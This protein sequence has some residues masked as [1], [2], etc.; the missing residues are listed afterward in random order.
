MRRVDLFQV[1]LVL[2]N[3]CLEDE[4]VPV[5]QVLDDIKKKVFPRPL[6]I[7]FN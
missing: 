1:P 5:I 6:E 3:C 4:K 7:L 2:V